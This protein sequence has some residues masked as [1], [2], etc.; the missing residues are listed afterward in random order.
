MQKKLTRRSDTIRVLHKFWKIMRL[1]VFIL[2]VFVAQAYSTVTYSQQT[3]LTLNMKGAKVIDV[4]NQIENESEFFF[5]FN[6]KLLDVEREV[7]VVVKNENIGNILCG[8]FEE[9]N[10]SY[11]I[12]DR[13]IILTTA[14]IG[15][16]TDQGQQR[17][18]RGKVTDS[19]GA[20]VPGVSIVIKGTTTGVIT[21]VNGNYSLD[22]VPSGA[23]LLFSFMGMQTQEIVVNNQ[24]IINIELKPDTKAID[25]VVI[26]GYGSQKRSDVIGSISQV[27]AEKI[28]HRTTPQLNQALTGQF[29]G[30]TVIQRSGQPGAPGGSIQI[31]GVGSFGAG[32]A[33]LILVDGIPVGSM[34]DIDPNDVENVSIL[35]DASSA[36]IYGS[37]AANGVIL[38][39]TKSGK[40]EEVK[41]SYNGYLGFQKPTQMPQFVDSWEY[42]ELFNEV[43]GGGA[44]GYTAEDIQKYKD[45]S[46]PDNYPN[47]HY[48]DEI[49][50]DHSIQTGHNLT[51]SQRSSKSDYLLSMGQMYQNGIVAEN[52]YNRYNVR[53]NLSSMLAAN[54]KM[55]ARIS[56]IFVQDHQPNSPASVSAGEKGLMG[57]INQAVRTPPIK[58]AK[59]SNGDYGLG[60]TGVGTPVS[61]LESDGFYKNRTTDLTGNLRLDWDVFNKILKFSLIGGYTQMDGRADTFNATQQLNPNVFLGPSTLSV[62]NVYSNYKTFQQLVEFDK[63]FGDHNVSALAVHSFETFFNENTKAERMDLPSNDIVVIDAGSADNQVTAGSASESALDSYFGRVKYNYDNRYLLEGVLRYDGSSRFP[64]D[65]KYAYF[66][67][68]AIGWRIS[69]EKFLKDRFSFLDDLKLKTSYGVLGNQNI[70]NYPYQSLFKSGFNYGFG[71]TVNTGVANTTL[72]DPNIHWESTRTYDAGFEARLW[73]G[74]LNLGVTWYDRYTYDILVSPNAS[75]SNVLGFGIGE[76]NSGSLEN[77]GWE[78]TVDHRNKIGELE[79]S[80]AANFAIVRNKVLDLGVANVNQPNGL[81]GNGSTLFIGY[82]LEIYYGYLTEGL[83]VDAEDVAAFTAT[84]NQSAINPAPK[85]GDI[86]YKDISGPDGVPDGKVNATYDRIFLGSM[87]PKYS[88]GLNLAAGYK[89]FSLEALIQAVSGVQGRLENHMAYA[90]N[91]SDGNVQRWQKEERWTLENPNPN[92]KYPRLENVPNTGTSNT[93]LSDYWVLNAS[94]VK[95]RFVELGYNLP[96]NLIKKLGIES[97]RLNVKA[98]NLLTIS[99]YRDGWDPEQN[100]GFL[101]YYPILANYTF[102]IAANF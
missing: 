5:L 72:V 15:T 95:L 19:T 6:Q 92:A 40:S 7:D 73:N 18:I 27:S 13:Q 81:V 77:K 82:P 41:V 49:F 9:T 66:P 20:S 2:V 50:K 68:A 4:L 33:P 8:I 12:K 64:S 74:K 57:I 22:N 94:Y 21:D 26:V 83:Y 100:A 63:A 1:S 38:I 47:V 31:R 58:P 93:V 79:Y 37:R 69:E 43:L 48:L 55:T 59:L 35:K 85:P 52:D 101:N 98:E 14:T 75:V 45:G 71:N 97:L 44:G 28:N 29:A 88:Y 30:V 62:T 87:I 96:V 23:T 60:V 3:L 86:K 76:T 53:F 67:S 54:L 34:N 17:P 24:R 89:G 102:G 78:F 99:S 84:N 32:T 90:F 25:E 39:T 36:A 61:L 46:D 42:A 91:T 80:I 65:R 56:G 16:Q 51:I 70:G 11:L 10:V